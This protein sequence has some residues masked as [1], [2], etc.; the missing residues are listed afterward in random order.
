MVDEKPLDT[1]AV[2]LDVSVPCDDRFRP[3]LN[4]LCERMAKYVGYTDSDATALT[5]AVVHATDGVLVHAGSPPYTH[6][7]VTISTSDDEIE[8]RVRYLQEGDTPSPD[9]PS[10]EHRLSE[11]NDDGTPLEVI[12]R[13]VRQVEFGHEGGVEYCALRK[14][15]PEEQ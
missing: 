14:A 13:V 1:R 6:L 9:T 12:Q 2:R 8:F 4:V 11:P 3:V 15:L 7:D 10:I 5:S